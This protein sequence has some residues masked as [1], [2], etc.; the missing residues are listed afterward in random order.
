MFTTLAVAL[1]LEADGD[2]A[3]PVV[4]ALAAIGD[5]DVELL[6]VD[7]PHVPEEVDAFELSR[8]AT[9]NGWPAHSYT[10]LRSDDVATAIVDHLDGRNGV[11]LVMSTT[12][13]RPAVGHV[14]G[15]VTEKVL[16]TIDQPVLLVGPNAAAPGEWEQVT[17]IICIDPTDTALDAV[18]SLR[19]WTQ[20]FRSS[21][22][23]VVEVI[24]TVTDW[25]PAADAFATSHVHSFTQTLAEHGIAANSE[26]LHGGAPEVWL[27]D[28]ADH[29]SNPFFVTTS[30]RWADGRP[31][32]HS[33]TRQLVQRSTRPVLV[34]PAHPMQARTGA[35]AET[36]SE[37]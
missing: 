8:R 17:P 25:D 1:D 27:D 15:S 21:P 24:P 9:A 20:T 34:V 35:G 30:T 14:L 6:T 19:S 23:W 31:H 18:P 29:T 4:R 3:L 36:A 2:R 10:V 7:S 32:W 37:V 5:V 16:R 26:V 12:A 11:L 13:K 22:P 33:A 28:F